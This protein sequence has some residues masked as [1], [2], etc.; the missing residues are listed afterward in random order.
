M[1]KKK[2]SSTMDITGFDI[3]NAAISANGGGENNAQESTT[4]SVQKSATKTK[5][6]KEKKVTVAP[7]NLPELPKNFQDKFFDNIFSYDRSPDKGRPVYIS[8]EIL[9]KLQELSERHYK[10]L[11]VRT[12]VQSVLASF[13]SYD[14]DKAVSDFLKKINF[15]VPTDEEQEK[16]KVAAEKARERRAAEKSNN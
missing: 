7:S 16:K 5:A 8:S 6:T 15:Q 11:C 12:L 13:L 4:E 9:G 1:A 3:A 2:N 10:R 14:T